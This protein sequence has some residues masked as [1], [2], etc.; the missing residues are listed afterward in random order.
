[1]IIKRIYNNN[2]IL[3]SDYNGKEVVLLGRGIGFQL[4]KGDAVIMDRIEKRFELDG[5]EQFRFQELVKDMPTDYI[6][7]ADDVIMFIKSK[8]S[9][10]LND[11]IYT[12]LTDHIANLAERI[13]M[14]IVFDN[15]L[16]WNIKQLY[17]VEYDIATEVVKMISDTLDVK[18]DKDEANFVALHIV[19]AETNTRMM[20]IYAITEIVSLINDIVDTHYINLDKEGYSYQRFMTH[21]RWFAHRVLNEV[22]K[23]ECNQRNKDTLMLLNQQYEKESQCL[24]EINKILKDKYSYD[25]KVDE[26]LYLMMHL[27]KLT[28]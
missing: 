11:S 14:G 1:M 7:L 22:P 27:V 4:S 26:S 16:L 5:E 20:E 12:T 21:C 3:A 10:P 15:S 23:Q 2:V 6:S 13:Q 24:L 18:I 17:P 19:N 9:E 28:T 8:I 25:V